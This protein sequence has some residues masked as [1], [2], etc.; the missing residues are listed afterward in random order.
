MATRDVGRSA[1]YRDKRYSGA[2]M[3]QGRVLTDDDFNSEVDIDRKVWLAR[4]HE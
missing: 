4:R 3:Q 1:F 2:Y